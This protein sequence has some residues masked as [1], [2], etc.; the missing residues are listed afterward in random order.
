MAT[1]DA[2]LLPLQ[3]LFHWEKSTPDKICLTQPM[4]GGALRDYTWSQLV[5]E[6]RRVAAFLQSFGWEPGTRIA[7]LS[8]N[9]AWWPMSDYAIW[10]AGYVSVP[11]YPTITAETVRQILEHSEAKA[12]F[13]GK[14]DDWD[15]MK[16]GVPAPVRCISFPLSPPNDFA[17]WDEIV[18]RTEPLAGDPVRAGD[19]LATIV[20]TSGTT[21][22]PKGVMHSF[23]TLGW[24]GDAVAKRY[25]PQ[26][27]DR[28]LS[29]LPLSH[30]AERVLGE[31]YVLRSGSLHVY[32]AESLE[33]F[34]A[35]LRRARPTRFFSVP[36]LW[37]KFQQ[38]VLAK[39]PQRKLDRLLGIPILCGI[40][41][42]KVLTGLGLDQCRLAA[43]GAAP[44]AP[45]LLDWY[46]KLGLE[47]VEGYGMTEN[48]ALSHST[49]P[50]KPRPGYVGLPYPG[51]ESRV[52]PATGEVQM[53]SP[54]L[55]L[56]YYKEPELTAATMTADGWLRTG[57]QAELAADGYLRIIGRVK[58]PFKTSKGKYVTPAP[59][60]DKLV[61]LPGVEAC[62]VAGANYGR[63]FGL[64]T[65][66]LEVLAG[67]DGSEA[68]R[69][70]MSSALQGH[71]A[72]INAT[73]DPHEQLEF[74]VVLKEQWTVDNGMIT[75]TMKF[76][77]D[78]IEKAYSPY[79][80]NWTQQGKAVIWEARSP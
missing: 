4:G 34:V 79:F 25:P 1:F 78:R 65:M 36:R 13:V 20:Y 5:N 2:D 18:R 3:R 33:T 62:C 60:E 31:L 80:D 16:P 47:I 46:A 11:L 7:I 41:R 29:Y 69:E 38:G 52:D 6:A 77:R 42:R 48:A 49:L 24:A 75:P 70:A 57:D 54:G 10:L 63:P 37:L 50:G 39:M 45:P 64:L 61:M 43:C 51:V 71:L 56:G 67:T 59:I 44:I 23:E 32:F 55:M 8:K 27:D 73:L 26:A 35:D 58:D 9:C 22:H 21:G 15:K 19:D 72:R 40:V 28:A 76:R 14:L 30:I 66:S 17:T 12:C 74:L 53:R 68:A